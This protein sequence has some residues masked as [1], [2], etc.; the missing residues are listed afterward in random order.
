MI[1]LTANNIHK[2]KAGSYV[3]YKNLDCERVYIITYIDS[4]SDNYFR[5]IYYTTDTNFIYT[6]QVAGSVIITYNYCLLDD[7]EIHHYHKL[8]IFSS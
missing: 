5:E 4:L 8:T 1:Q 6:K 7:N 3:L 2:L